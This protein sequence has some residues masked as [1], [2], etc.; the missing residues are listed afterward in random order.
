[1][2]LVPSKLQSSLSFPLLFSMMIWVKN[3]I[4]PGSSLCFQ[5][6]LSVLCKLLWT[7]CYATWMSLSHQWP[8]PFSIE[9]EERHWHPFS[10]LPYSSYAWCLCLVSLYW[11]NCCFLFLCFVSHG[12]LELGCVCCAC[13]MYVL[14]VTVNTLSFMGWPFGNYCCIC[15]QYQTISKRVI[16]MVVLLIKLNFKKYPV[17]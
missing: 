8:C 14:G 6:V 16:V 10:C 9:L 2:H 13:Y 4:P 15:K 5:N 3:L 17:S 1:M 7:F 12:S 11:M